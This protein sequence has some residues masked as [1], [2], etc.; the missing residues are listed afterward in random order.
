MA[1]SKTRACDNEGLD[2]SFVLRT[3]APLI[4][5]AQNPPSQSFGQSMIF[6]S[7]LVGLRTLSTVVAMPVSFLVLM[8]R[9]I[10]MRVVMIVFVRIVAGLFDGHFLKLCLGNQALADD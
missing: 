2:T 6:I 5:G 4:P 1:A 7:F 8:L 9:V 10:V 3:G